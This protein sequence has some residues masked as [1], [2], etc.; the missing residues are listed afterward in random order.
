MFKHRFILFVLAACTA[1]LLQCA[2]FEDSSVYR[3]AYGN[4]IAPAIDAYPFLPGAALAIPRRARCEFPKGQS[5]SLLMPP[6]QARFSQFRCV[7]A[8]K[9]PEP[10]ARAGRRLARLATFATGLLRVRPRGSIVSNNHHIH[11]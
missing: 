4:P 10:I 5:A 1:V 6:R 7:G 3:R 9:L 8:A 2:F 11:N